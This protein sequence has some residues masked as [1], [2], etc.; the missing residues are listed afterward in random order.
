MFGGKGG[1]GK[2]TFS[3][4]MGYYLAQEGIAL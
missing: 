2:T 4:A 1:L 3:A